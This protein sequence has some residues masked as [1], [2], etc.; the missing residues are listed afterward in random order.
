VNSALGLAGGAGR[1]QKRI[2]FVGSSFDRWFSLRARRDQVLIGSVT[3]GRFAAEMYVLV[4]GDQAL[5]SDYLNA[6]EKIVLD[7]GGFSF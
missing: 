5:G 4:L 1:V 3:S 2:G 7:D 6:V